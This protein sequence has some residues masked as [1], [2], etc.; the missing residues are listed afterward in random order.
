MKTMG[1][2]KIL[3]A[4][5][6]MMSIGNSSCLRHNSTCSDD[7]LGFLVTFGR[8]CIQRC[9]L[10]EVHRKVRW[11]SPSSVRAKAV[12]MLAV[13]LCSVF[14]LSSPLDPSVWWFRQA[15]SEG[16]V[17]LSTSRARVGEKGDHR[18]FGDP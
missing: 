7:G 18:G 6:H 2:G 15:F 5:W 9:E 10:G 17:L 14:V 16:C 3:N 13:V 8:L 1:L 4:S 11:P 12:F